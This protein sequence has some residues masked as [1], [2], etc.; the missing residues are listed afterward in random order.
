MKIEIENATKFLVELMKN[1]SASQC[2]KL[3]EEQLH[4]F[5]LV[6]VECL[7]NYYADHWFPETPVKG[8]GYRCIRINGKVDP[9]LVKAGHIM[10]LAA[11][12][13]H[14][15]FPSEFTMWVDPHEVSYRIGENGSICILYETE[16]PS[17]RASPTTPPNKRIR[18]SPEPPATPMKV[19]SA[20]YQQQVTPPPPSAL[21]YHFSP[22]NNR[23]ASPLQQQYQLLQQQQQQHNMALLREATTNSN[24]KDIMRPNHVLPLERL[25]VSS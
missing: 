18:S 3:S 23:R 5:R 8:S 15:M 12:I 10:G 11:T 16:N 22:S 17:Q 2:S 14:S 7:T 13:I 19:L 25:F 4:R 24:C 20:L 6:V 1:G 9:I 21:S